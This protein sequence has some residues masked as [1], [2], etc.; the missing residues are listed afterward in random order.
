MLKYSKLDNFN[1]Y[2]WKE[3]MKLV[4]INV[5]TS[6]EAE[7]ALSYI[8]LEMGSG[9]VHAED[10]KSSPGKVIVSAYFPLDDTVGE[11]VFNLRSS[12]DKL[13]EIMPEARK[14]K[15]TFENID[16]IDWSERWKANFKPITVGKRVIIYPSWE[17]IGTFSDRDVHIKI[18][19]G[20]AFGTGKHA[21]TIL[22][23]ELLE[24]AIQ[25][26]EEVADIGTGSGIL[27]IAS[28]KL[29]ARHVVAIDIDEKSVQIAKE[30]CMDNGV[31][32]K[33]SI[34]T[35]DLLS[36][37]KGNYNVIVANIHTKILLLMLPYIKDYLKSNGMIILSGIL[38]KEAFEIE[39]ELEKTNFDIIEKP[40]LEEWVAFL[41]KLKNK[42]DL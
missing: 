2:K 17:G 24:K 4:R 35:G 20:M 9:G 36:S 30:N 21:T 11:R 39:D 7:E 34:M 40:Q 14:S 18:D 33:V 22:S 8:F 29:G 10:V 5:E 6:I 12:L 32:D 15:I 3:I 31:A 26:N 16:D 41:A 23:L 13:S 37:V 27:S 1:I 19:P 25:G 38:D 42:E 28:V